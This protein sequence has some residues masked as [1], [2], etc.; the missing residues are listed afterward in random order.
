MD[1]G[2][3][4]GQS[5]GLHLQAESLSAELLYLSIPRQACRY[6]G[7]ASFVTANNTHKD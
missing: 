4:S 1:V 2:H 7:Y 6:I 3:A 5:A